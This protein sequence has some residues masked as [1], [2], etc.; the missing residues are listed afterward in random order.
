MAE[1]ELIYWHALPGRGDFVRLLFEEAGVP[2]T[3][4]C[5]N[6]GSSSEALKYRRGEVP[7]VPT[8]VPPI[9]RRGDFILNQTTA[10]LHY[11]GKEFGLYPTGGHQEEA[12]ALQWALTAADYIAEG[13]DCFHPLDKTGSYDSQKAEAAPQIKKF[14]E[15]RMPAYLEK[16]EKQFSQNFG[17]AGFF[18]GDEVVLCEI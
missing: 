10:I 13:H 14:R 16:F 11:L 15:I 8:M 12:V 3:D 1:W 9:V 6:A 5:R 2:Y 18:I 4:V 7:N 17:G